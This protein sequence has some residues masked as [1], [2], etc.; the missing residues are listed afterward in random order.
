MSRAEVDALWSVAKSCNATLY[1]LLVTAYATLLHRWT[2]Q[3]DLLVGTP[4]RGRTQPETEELIGFFVNTLVLRLDASGDPTL[5]ELAERVRTTCLEAFAHPDMPFELLVKELGTTRDLSRTPV[6]Q[7]FFSF[8][9]AKN[10]KD[11][12]G[13]LAVTQVHVMPDAAQNDLVLWVMERNDGMVGGLSYNSDIFEHATMERF[14][15]QFRTV[16]VEAARDVGA[17]IGSLRILPDA[18]LAALDGWRTPRHSIQSSLLLPQCVCR[19]RC[20]DNLPWAVA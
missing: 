4:I 11:A 3:T 2:G 12:M 1:M 14:L 7:A 10:R 16:L 17:H 20:S 19:R 8:Q 5:R 13:D 15:A 9:D 18:E 6:F